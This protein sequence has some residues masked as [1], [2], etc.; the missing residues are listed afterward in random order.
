MFNILL[1]EDSPQMYFSGKLNN[2]VKLGVNEDEWLHRD[3]GGE[4]VELWSLE[5]H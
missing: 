4:V 5:M 2:G 1:H 3:Y